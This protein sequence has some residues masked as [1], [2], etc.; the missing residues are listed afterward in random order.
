MSVIDLITVLGYTITCFGSGIAIGC[1]ISDLKH[2][3]KQ[4]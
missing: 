4:K 1:L 2:N 3:K